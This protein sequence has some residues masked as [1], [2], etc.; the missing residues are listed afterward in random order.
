MLRRY[1]KIFVCIQGLGCTPAI[2]RDLPVA[3]PNPPQNEPFS[4][5][6]MARAPRF[7][8]SLEALPAII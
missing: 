8:L 1:G 7:S 6:K 4:Y 3:R 5:L 2:T